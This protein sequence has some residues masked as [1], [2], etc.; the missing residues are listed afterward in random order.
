VHRCAFNRLRRES[1]LHRCA[2]NRLRRESCSQRCASNRLRRESCSHR[3][4]TPKPP[5]LGGRLRPAHSGNHW[6]V[7]FERVLGAVFDVNGFK[8]FQKL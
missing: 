7:E 8:Q 1:C 4:S 5:I 2:F 3:L 6:L